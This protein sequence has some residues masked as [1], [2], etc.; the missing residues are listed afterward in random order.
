ME[1]EGCC[2]DCGTYMVISLL[3]DAPL[4]VH[5]CSG[6]PSAIVIAGAAVF[7]VDDSY[8]AGLLLG[9]STMCGRITEYDLSR[10]CCGKDDDAVDVDALISDLGMA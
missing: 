1:F 7:N 8:A 5:R 4:T 9:K 2:P 3:E 6:C 10:R